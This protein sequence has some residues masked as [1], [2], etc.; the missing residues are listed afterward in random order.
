[1][2]KK[3]FYFQG[4]SFDNE[5]DFWTYV[6]EWPFLQLDESSARIQLKTLSE[7]IIVDVLVRKMNITNIEFNGLLQEVLFFS[8]KKMDKII[9]EKKEE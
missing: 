7:S 5:E 4:K 6:N 3:C 2:D 1:M 8:L 9:E